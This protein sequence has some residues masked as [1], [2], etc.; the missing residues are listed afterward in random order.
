MGGTRRPS[1]RSVI[2]G[3]VALGAGASLFGGRARAAGYPERAITILCPFAA[4][5]PTDL[6]ARIVAAHLGQ[7]LGQP[8]VMD[9]VGD[10]V[11]D[12]INAARHPRVG[13]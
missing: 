9:G 6:C 10:G 7:K 4:G 3:A 2:E 1:R 5:G 8:A 11:A 13:G 12:E